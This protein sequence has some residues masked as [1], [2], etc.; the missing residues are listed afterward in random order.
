V[1]GHP[2]VVVNHGAELEHLAGDL[3]ARNLEFVLQLDNLVGGVYVVALGLYLLTHLFLPLHHQLAHLLHV[4][5]G[6]AGF[7]LIH[8]DHLNLVREEDC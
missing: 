8:P 7:L 6:H 4:Q 1:L 2:L 3:L 5:V